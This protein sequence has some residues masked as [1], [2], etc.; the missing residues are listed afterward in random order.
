MIYFDAVA[1]TLQKPDAVR[2]AMDEDDDSSSNLRLSE[3]KEGPRD[4]LPH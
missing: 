1:T 4:E 3:E 2:R